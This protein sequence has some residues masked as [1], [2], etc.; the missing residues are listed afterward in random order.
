MSLGL[1][2]SFAGCGG[3][4]TPPKVETPPQTS[5]PVKPATKAAPKGK[6]GLAADGEISAQDRRAAKLKEKK[7]AGQ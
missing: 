5:T 3:E 4:P 1:F 6:S 2:F 7:A